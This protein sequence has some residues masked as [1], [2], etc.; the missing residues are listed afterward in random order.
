[1][2]TIQVSPLSPVNMYNAPELLASQLIEGEFTFD[3]MFKTLTN[4][5]RLSIQERQGLADRLKEASGRNAISN[6]FIDIA[7][8]PWVWFAFITT[9][10][11]AK[12]L[13][14]GKSIF[15]VGPE[16][17]AAIRK[18]T[19]FLHSL[20][21]ATALQTLDGTDAA[22]LALRAN[23]GFRRKREV[24]A[25]VIGKEEEQILAQ[26]GVK[27][28]DPQ[29]ISNPQ[30]RE[31]VQRLNR[32]LAA[33]LDGVDQDIAWQRPELSVTYKDGAG[34]KITRGKWK[35]LDEGARQ[36][37]IEV[38]LIDQMDEA[39]I[40]DDTLDRIIDSYGARPL[41]EKMRAALTEGLKMRMGKEGID[42]FELDEGKVLRLWQSYRNPIFNTAQQDAFAD[43][44]ALINKI[45]GEDGI[46][47]LESGS[48][49][50]DQFLDIVRNVVEPGLRHNSYF[51]RGAS[52]EI[53]GDRGRVYSADLAATRN[54]AKALKPGGADIGRVARSSF[55]H[56]ED[57]RWLE[58]EGAST[59]QA[60]DEAMKRA[61][62]M[63]VKAQSGNQAQSFWRMNASHALS[64]YFDDSA[65]TWA[66]YHQTKDA[67]A[68]ATQDMYPEFTQLKSRVSV[69]REEVL[70]NLGLGDSLA[71]EM[72]KTFVATGEHLDQYAQDAITQVVVPGATNKLSI[73]HN[74]SRSA[75]ISAK[76]QLHHFTHSKIGTLIE[77]SSGLGGELI[78]RLRFIADSPTDFR[79][80][81]GITGGIAKALYGSH[82]GLNLGSTVL[83]MTQ[84]WLHLAAI[85]GSDNV[86]KAYGPAL[87]EVVGYTRDRL[88]HGFGAISPATE[89]QLIQKHFKYASVDGED[90]IGIAPDVIESL[91]GVAA[92]YHGQSPVKGVFD[93][94]FE[95]IMA[96]FMFA[97]RLNRS[98]AAHAVEFAYAKEA[99]SLVGTARMNRDVRRTVLETQFGGHWLNQ[100]I[101]L[102][103]GS[104]DLSAMGRWLTNPIMRQFL[105]F[106][107]R[108]ATFFPE[109]SR[110]LGGRDGAGAAK[111]ALYDFTRAMGISAVGI[112]L[113]RN[114]VGVDMERAGIAEAQF[115]IPK[116]LMGQE[117]RG[118][119]PPLFDIGKDVLQAL[120]EQD[121]ALLGR[122]I[123]RTLPA[124]IA[125]Q[126]VLNA[127]PEA[128]S[129]LVGLPKTLQTTYADW[130]NPDDNGRVPIYR[131]DGTF[132]G[133]MPPHLILLKGA[134]LDLGKFNKESEVTAFLANNR[135]EIVDIKGKWITATLNGNHRKAKEI[136]AHFQKRF[137]FQLQVSKD[138]IRR[139]MQNRS[140]PRPE[141]VLDK[142]PT[143]ARQAYQELV[144]QS[145][146]DR[147][148]TTPE[149]IRNVGTSSRRQRFGAEVK[150]DPKTA[151]ILRD[152][153]EQVNARRIPNTAEEHRAFA[154]YRGF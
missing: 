32:A 93:R 54:A 142:I 60:F 116:L 8:N 114:L 30:K 150:M 58:Q 103:S 18:N 10:Q 100:P 24:L 107:W 82:L 140:T 71:D 92:A 121:R 144:A 108:S 7:T 139:A 12:A 132:M 16:Y 42:H 14:A 94:G 86:A 59:T 45:M 125:G 37:D 73:R 110:K 69:G 6:A 85:V 25:T 130:Q 101:A 27:T 35:K 64:R 120:T 21:G 109:M 112:S 40:T 91:E 22:E 95:I 50:S 128:P 102:V 29:R 23:E 124:G 131:G 134:G 3:G 11:G 147:L 48:V 78:S 49:T 137:G 20:G 38:R 135:E 111:A 84:P 129:W 34:Q 46:A 138:Q 90:L 122:T 65:E 51:P 53:I 66:W 106:P 43:G 19:P 1:M 52:A 36:V 117:G 146:P 13:R 152:R 136:A 47:L 26:L 119:T 28:L 115:E 80:V 149:Q 62:S 104:E 143:E 77:E 154:S 31:A 99:P 87:K 70:R 89:R 55:W 75:L 79:E 81:G 153:I 76:Q 17:T 126:R 141:R 39:L 5:N 88:A 9:P 98:V 148:N 68:E 151:Q 44:R 123:A 61:D 2:S 96:P 105:Q 127:L 67:V 145:V 41:Y 57:L 118:L 113:A 33:K 97:E 63:M 72:Y 74:A 83:N 133:V 15:Q 56:P 4:P